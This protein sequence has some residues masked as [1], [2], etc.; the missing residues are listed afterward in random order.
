[1]R[2]GRG[3]VRRALY[4]AA[5]TVVRRPGE[6]GRFYQR[7]RKR[8][9]GR[10]GGPRSG[11]AQAPAA[12]EYHR[13]PRRPLDP[14]S[15]PAPLHPNPLTQILTINTDT[16][17]ANPARQPLA[18][19]QACPQRRRGL[20]CASGGAAKGESSPPSSL[21]CNIVLATLWQFDETAT[22]AM[23]LTRWAA[24]VAFRRPAA[25][26]ARRTGTQPAGSVGAGRPAPGCSNTRG[27][28]RA[29]RQPVRKFTLALREPHANCRTLSWRL[30]R[31]K[32]V[33]DL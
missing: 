12:S 6:L 22:H 5:L 17:A 9:Q 27:F 21:P 10:Q 26:P 11:D 13:P 19:R 33:M 30:P 7:L 28:P 2:G 14:Q 32:R 24:S 18:L 15:T 16:P 1:M 4:M 31:P 29:L 3:A 8:G 25:P 23:A 20:P